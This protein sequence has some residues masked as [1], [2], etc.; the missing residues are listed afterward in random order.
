M[1]PKENFHGATKYGTEQNWNR[2]TGLLGSMLHETRKKKLFKHRCYREPPTGKDGW[3]SGR[4]CTWWWVDGPTFHRSL[5]VFDGVIKIMTLHAPYRHGTANISTKSCLQETKNF[6][7]SSPG[8]TSTRL[9]SLQAA[10]VLHF[11]SFCGCPSSWW[12]MNEWWEKCFRFGS[13][14][15]NVE[16]FSS[17]V[18]HPAVGSS[19]KLGRRDSLITATLTAT[20]CTDG[21]LDLAVGYW[22]SWQQRR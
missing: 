21:V 15:R 20:D 5:A 13:A 14:R 18:F 7:L 22:K 6:K 8:T 2:K 19:P 10:A 4:A 16:R 9:Y 17:Q 11:L 3:W 12:T 1:L